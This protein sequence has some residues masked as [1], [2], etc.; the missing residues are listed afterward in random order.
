M[1]AILP[2]FDG[3]SHRI[4]LAYWYRELH[5]KLPTFYLQ[6]LFMPT[7]IMVSMIFRRKLKVECTA[8]VRK[9]CRIQNGAKET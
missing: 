2:T 9:G 3:L 1:A 5:L 4:Y 6:L 8:C 7:K